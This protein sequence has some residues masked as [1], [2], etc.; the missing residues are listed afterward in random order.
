MAR[1]R[2]KI[3]GPLDLTYSRRA[4]GTPGG[5]SRYAKGPIIVSDAL[6]FDIDDLRRRV[7]QLEQ[8]L[9]SDSE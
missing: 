5:P 1:N 9:R 6:D 7:E 3:L 4:D 2:R 8:R